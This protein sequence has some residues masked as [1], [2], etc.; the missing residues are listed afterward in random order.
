MA[1]ARNQHLPTTIHF[2]L[3]RDPPIPTSRS[4]R[5][6]M[7]H[8]T[9]HRT[10]SHLIASVSPHIVNGNNDDDDDGNTFSSRHNRP[11]SQPAS[12]LHTTITIRMI[13]SESLA[14]FLVRGEGKVPPKKGQTSLEEDGET[15]YGKRWRRINESQIESN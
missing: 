13:L 3:A 5:E 1:T 10:I 4:H 11:A 2:P 12:Q 9:S 8:T 14:N 7:F 6:P 15:S